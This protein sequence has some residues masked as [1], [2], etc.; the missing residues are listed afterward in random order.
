MKP[1]DSSECN[2]KMT[3]AAAVIRS[4][5]RLSDATTMTDHSYKANPPL[6]SEQR[7]K[8]FDA[9]IDQITNLQTPSLELLQKLHSMEECL[10][11]SEHRKDVEMLLLHPSNF[12][13]DIG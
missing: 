1:I 6:C 8:I 5:N 3:I 2:T 9:L 12:L 4:F 13:E 10:Q 7:K 11:G